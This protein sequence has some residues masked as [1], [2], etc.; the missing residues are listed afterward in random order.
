MALPDIVKHMAKNMPRVWR[1]LNFGNIVRMYL[2]RQLYHPEYAA[3]AGLKNGLLLD[4]G[5]NTGQS[6][7]SFAIVSPQSS[8]LSIEPNPR[9]EIEL[10]AVK[11]IL[12]KRFQY[13]IAAAGASAG[14]LTLYIPIKGKTELTQEG[15]FFPEVLEDDLAYGR[16]GAPDKV[17]ERLVPVLKL[18]ELLLH[19]VG[20]KIDV[21]G[22]EI[23]VLEG[24]HK[25]IEASRPLIMIEN[26]KGIETIIVQMKKIGY[27]PKLWIKDQFV[28]YSADSIA[29]NV[30]FASGP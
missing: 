23:S 15:S 11:K 28:S 26:Q 16:F 4:I 29:G 14:Q 9:C 12:G 25:T 7:F 24:L 5:A 1:I 27:E 17:I 30:F 22:N 13:R 3:F 20:I 10:R 2:F 18:D 19:V 6:A 8:V 21:Q